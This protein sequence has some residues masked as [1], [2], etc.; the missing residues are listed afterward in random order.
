MGVKDRPSSP[1]APVP[2]PPRRNN[3]LAK[4]FKDPAD[5][6][7]VPEASGLRVVVADVVQRE[8]RLLHLAR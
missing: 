2:A 3:A 7:V 8:L 1:T 6:Y 5:F 4:G